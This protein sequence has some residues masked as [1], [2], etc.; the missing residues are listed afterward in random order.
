MQTARSLSP[1]RARHSRN[2]VYLEGLKNALA[3]GVMSTALALIIAMPLAFLTDRF[4]FP[5][6][7]LFS[8]LVLVPMILPPFVGAIGIR[9]IFGQMGAFNALLAHLGLLRAD[10]LPIDWLGH[11]RFWG[12]VAMNALHL[13]PI[14]YLN[15]AAALANIDPAM[16]EAA[17]NLGCTGLR[18]FFKITL[19]LIMPGLFAGGTIVFIWAF[20]ELGVPLMFDYTRVTPVQIFYGLKEI[21]GNPFPYTLVVITLVSTALLYLASKLLFGRADYMAAS[22]AATESSAR[23]LGGWRAALCT[24]LFACVTFIALLP[25]LGVVL[26]SFAGDW[27]HSALPNTWTL[28]HYKEALGHDLTVPS[29]INSLKYS[30]LATVC[31]LLLGVVIAWVIVRTQNR[32]RHILDAAAMLPLAVPGLVLAFGYIAMTQEGRA[33]SFLNPARDPTALLVIAYAVRRLPFVR[34]LGH[35]AGLQQTS[36]TLEE[37]AMNLGAPPLRALRR[38]T[39][40]LIAANILAGGLLAF[41]FAMLEVSDSLILAQR[42]VD[43][44]ITKAIFEL[45]QNPGQRTLH[46]LG[47]SAN[48]GNGLPRPHHPGSIA[49]P[50][51]K[52][53]RA[54]P[55]IKKHRSR[56]KRIVPLFFADRRHRA[57]AGADDRFIG[58]RENLLAIGAQGVGVGDHAA[59]HR[60]C[61][62]R[63]AHHRQRLRPAPLTKYVIPPARMP[64]RQPCFNAQVCLPQKPFPPQMA[65]RH[66]LVRDR[67]RTPARPFFP[68]AGRGRI[69]G[70]RACV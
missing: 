25:H 27:Y 2:P 44:P 30:S 38:I 54:L 68:S 69:H 56:K 55:R 40:P 9:E 42:S 4:V 64:P 47:R 51:Q 18:K 49:P 15:I 26:V 59:A 14:L 24:G 12:V 37:A 32:W 29:I 35:A 21:G 67:K 34:A 53:G 20:T 7:K 48:L 60:A 16:E 11:E 50:G 31:D 6:K 43:F 52:D 45:F 62:K 1:T 8:A 39:L 57:V 10:A 17:E 66:P 70:R 36:P 46:R 33:F 63:V 58:Q 19:P 22:K 65:R 23:R 28:A 61:E 41:S 13:Y 3:M 5:G